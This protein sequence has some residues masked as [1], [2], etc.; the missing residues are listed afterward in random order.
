MKSSKHDYPMSETLRTGALLALVGGF[1]DAYTYI[2]RG[3]VFANAQ[4][5]NVVLLALNIA[6]GNFVKAVSYLIPI[7]A[8]ILGIF[9]SELIH[10]R[11]PK[12]PL[13]WRQ[14]IVAL[15]IVTVCIVAFIP[16][17]KGLYSY[18][19]LANVIISY[20]CSL[21]VQ[22]FRRI[23]GIT[24]AT[25]MCTGNL[26]SGT[27][28][29]MRYQKGRNKQDLIDGFKY[30][31]IN[32]IFIVGAIISVFVTRQFGGLSVIFCSIPLIIVFILMFFSPRPASRRSQFRDKS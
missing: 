5:G 1:F 17:E 20:V 24:A 3:G 9:T 31:L 32:L 21:Q 22:A 18:N 27:D 4:T 15:E 26:R 28:L 7:L 6:E 13:H 30:Y 11:E 29:L 25:T 16:T 10:S 14:I 12:L 19:M 23:H 2:A 8:F